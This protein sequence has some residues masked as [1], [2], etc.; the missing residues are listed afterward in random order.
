MVSRISAHAIAVCALLA[1]CARFP[2][3][4]IVVDL[5]VLAMKADVP[6]QIVDID[7]SD[8][9]NVATLLA[10]MVPAQVC[11]LVTDPNFDRDL[12]WSMQLCPQ[13]L[14]DR[15][16]AGL[17]AFT[18]GS[19]VIPDMDLTVPE[20]SLCATVEPDSN[21][22][23][24]VLYE[25]ADDPL[26]GLGGEEYDV[27][28]R[29]GGVDA[30]PSLDLYA[31]KALNVAPRDPPD[32]TPNLNPYL[33]VI[34]ATINGGPAA[35]VAFGRCIDQ[36]MPQ[37]VPSGG[38]LRLTPVEPPGIHQVYTL[39]LVDGTFETF[40]ESISYQ[41]SAGVGGSFTQD[42]SGG[43]PDSFGNTPPIYTDWTAPTVKTPTQVSL[44]VVQRDERL[45]VAWY[46]MCFDVVP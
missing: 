20:P 26:Q 3:Q 42:T 19:G 15:C 5:R 36:A 21:L 6:E 32:R 17:P 2:D 29:V 44:W 1:S 39:P 30:D 11:G 7:P 37:K 4:A 23:D 31:A 38:D 27:V 35:A 24:V 12:R 25:L 43:P 28:M 22:A 40:T 41:W 8:P 16:D 13:S 14:D 45:G 18:I 9:P 34:D 10:Q 33:N 46:Q